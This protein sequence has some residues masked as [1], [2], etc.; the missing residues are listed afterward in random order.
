MVAND[1]FLAGGCFYDNEEYMCE[2]PGVLDNQVGYAN[3][4]AKK[5]QVLAGKKQYR[6]CGDL[7]GRL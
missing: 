1:I 7:Q 3:G 6:F 5:S 2:L 4:Y